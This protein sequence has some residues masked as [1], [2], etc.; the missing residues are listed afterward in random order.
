MSGL[1][2]HKTSHENAVTVIETLEMSCVDTTLA[3]R[4]I[5]E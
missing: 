5:A 3:N 2:S 1:S 4:I